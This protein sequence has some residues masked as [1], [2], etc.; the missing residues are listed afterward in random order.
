M[1]YCRPANIGTWDWFVRPHGCFGCYGAFVETPRK[2]NGVIPVAPKNFQI[3]CKEKMAVKV[4][5][6]Y[7]KWHDNKVSEELKGE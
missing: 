3:P 1:W 4:Q 2:K 7:N 5:E 6:Q